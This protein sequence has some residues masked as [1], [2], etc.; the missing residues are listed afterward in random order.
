MR[1]TIPQLVAYHSP[2]T[3]SAGDLLTTGTI[4]GV[5]AIRPNPFDF[6]LKPGDVVEAELHEGDAGRHARLLVVA[7]ER[8][9]ELARILRP[10]GHLEGA[11]AVGLGRLDLHHTAGSH[12]DHGHGNDAVLVVPHLSHADLLADDRLVRHGGSF[13]SAS[14]D[15]SITRT[16]R[17]GKAWR[18]AG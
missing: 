7:G 13:S 16:L 6:Y 3:Y 12:F 8:L 4:S 14:R 15:L 17:A 2:Q 10:E 9:V 1:V 11:V 5:A 18:S